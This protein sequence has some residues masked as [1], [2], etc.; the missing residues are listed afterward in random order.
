VTNNRPHTASGNA[1]ETN[2][3]LRS[4]VPLLLVLALFFVVAEA[5][6]ADGRIE[7]LPIAEAGSAEEATVGLD[8]HLGAKIPLDA[9]FRDESGKTVR[10]AELITG[11][12]LILPVYYSCPNVCYNLQWGLA[13]VIPQLKSKPGVEYRVISI[14]F[15]E[16]D[17]PLLASKFKRVYLNAMHA[18]FPADGWRFLTGDP[19]SIR[20]LMNTAGYGFQRRGRDFLH[21]AASFIVS[22][23]GTIVRYLY[24]TNILPKDL[25]LALIEARDGTSGVTIR[26][27]VEYCFTFDPG[28]KTYVFNL[29]R[30]SATVVIICAGGFLVFLIMTGRKRKQRKQS[31]SR[32]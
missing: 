31:E 1:G 17:T 8:E 11:P 28:E 18:Q 16:H 24:G 13:Q 29:L 7:P 19:A 9:T 10:L 21:P 20:S 4:L 2:F 30:V 3:M 22:G 25:A 23:D 6:S 27:M 26:K 5:R 14:S 12:T 15:D 32:K